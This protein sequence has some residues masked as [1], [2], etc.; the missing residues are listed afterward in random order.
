M[1]FKKFSCYKK[2]S[3]KQK[4]MISSTYP[5]GQDNLPLTPLINTIKNPN[6]CV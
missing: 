1:G 3:A 2:K 6:F 4:Q 5:T